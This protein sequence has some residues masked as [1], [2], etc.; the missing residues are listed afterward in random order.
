MLLTIVV[1]TYVA[2]PWI[3]NFLDALRGYNPIYPYD[4]KDLTRQDWVSRHGGHV[5]TATPGNLLVS[6]VLVL[7]VVLVWMTVLPRG[8][9]RRD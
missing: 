2:V 9:T 4:P 1:V 7:L 5:A 3:A 8:G 6:I